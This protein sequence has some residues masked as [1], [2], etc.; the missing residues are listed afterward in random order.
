MTFNL[1]N[2]KAE[3]QEFAQKK[4]RLEE[5]DQLV[6]SMFEN[7]FLKDAGN[8]QVSNVDDPLERKHL[9]ESHSKRKSQ[10]QP[11]RRQT[12]LFEGLNLHKS[13]DKN[14]MEDEGGLD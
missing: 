7:G 1:E 10:I 6:E 13:M 9:A 8:G 4:Q 11:N 3:Y 2:L 12:Q 14:A 5:R